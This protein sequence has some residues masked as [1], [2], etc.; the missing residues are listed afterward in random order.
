MIA[1][2]DAFD[3]ARTEAQV[4]LELDALP[5]VPTVQALHLLERARDRTLRE[6][7]YALAGDGR[8]PD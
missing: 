1:E 5:R 4:Q 7:L 2:V 8:R 6:H 3:G